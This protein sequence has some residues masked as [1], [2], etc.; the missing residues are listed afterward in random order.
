MSNMFFF[1]IFMFLCKKKKNSKEKFTLEE[2]PN[3][4]VQLTNNSPKILAI[5]YLSHL[6]SYNT[7]THFHI[8]PK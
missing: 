1:V 2:I 3:Y 6:K 8:I 4:F 5:T 7:L